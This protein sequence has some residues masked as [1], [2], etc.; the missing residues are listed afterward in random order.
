MGKHNVSTALLTKGRCL[1]NDLAE[2]Q[3]FAVEDVF[4]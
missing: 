2:G 1:G 3:G 4:V